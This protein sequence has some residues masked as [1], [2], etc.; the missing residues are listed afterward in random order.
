MSNGSVDERL[1]LL[2]QERTPE[3]FMDLALREAKR[4]READEVPVGAV[5]VDIPTGRL[6]ARAHNQREL[7]QDPTAH[8]E[9]LAITQAAAHY[10]SWRLT[11]AMLFV[12][13]EPCLMC[14]GAIVL[15]RLPLVC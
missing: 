1:A 8:A 14:A 3:S 7:L 10:G 2:F 6:I 15:A 11:D 9:V 4:A 13:L 5:I 12:T